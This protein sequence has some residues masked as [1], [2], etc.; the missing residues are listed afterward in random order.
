MALQTLGHMYRGGL[1]D[2]IG[3]GCSRYST[4]RRWLIP[5]FE[6]MLYDNALLA[7]TTLEAFQMTSRSFFRTMA[8]QT[9]QYLLREL[10]SPEGGFYCGQDADSDGKEGAYY[11]F[12]PQEIRASTWPQG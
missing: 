9:L 11:G 6:K 8:E 7:Y 12:T 3:G 2:H 10:T 1:F 4:D 5:H